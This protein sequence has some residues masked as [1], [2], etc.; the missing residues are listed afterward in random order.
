MAS[1]FFAAIMACHSR[2]RVAQGLDRKVRRQKDALDAV[3][4]LA[5]EGPDEDEVDVAPLVRV[6]SSER[7]VEVDLFQAESLACDRDPVP[8]GCT[9]LRQAVKID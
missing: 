1:G 2:G 8:Q 9:N 3:G 7:P 6:S 4:E 5:G